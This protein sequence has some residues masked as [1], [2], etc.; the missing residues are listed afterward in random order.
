M[1]E[2]ACRMLLR[3]LR[4]VYCSSGWR[5]RMNRMVSSSALRIFDGEY[6]PYSRKVEQ[7]VH[8][9]GRDR[10]GRDGTERVCAA[11]RQTDSR[12]YEEFSGRTGED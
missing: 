10:T 11:A 6:S 9:T 5:A 12:C 3:F 8:W 4:L 7:T 2:R 1:M